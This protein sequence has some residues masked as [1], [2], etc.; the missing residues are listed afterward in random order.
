MGLTTILVPV[1]LLILDDSAKKQMNVSLVLVLTMERAW[2]EF[3]TLLV[4][5]QACLTDG[6]VKLMPDHHAKLYW[7]QDLLQLDHTL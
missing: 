2:M 3:T 5:V 4:F 7:P 1:L 6:V